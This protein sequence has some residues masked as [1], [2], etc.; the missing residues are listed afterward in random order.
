MKNSVMKKMLA[1]LLALLMMIPMTVFSIAAEQTVAQNTPQIIPVSDGTD[2]SDVGDRW[3]G[4]TAQY[5]ADGTVATIVEGVPALQRPGTVLEMV[6]TTKTARDISN[7]NTLVFDL[8]LENAVG[9]ANATFYFELRSL[10]YTGDDHELQFV[11]ELNSLVDYILK[12]GWHHIEIPLS[13]FGESADFDPT[14]WSFFRIYNSAADVALRENGEIVKDEDGNTVYTRQNVQNTIGTAGK[15]TVFKI[16]NMY[17]TDAS[18]AMPTE[19]DEV[20]LKMGIDPAKHVIN[21]TATADIPAAAPPL[22]FV[23][24]PTTALNI[25]QYSTVNFDVYL[26]HEDAQQREYFLELTSSGEPDKEEDLIKSKANNWASLAEFADMAGIELSAGWNRI[27]IPVSARTK[28]T[29]MDATQFDFFRIYNKSWVKGTYADGETRSVVFARA[30]LG[31]YKMGGAEVDFWSGSSTHGVSIVSTTHKSSVADVIKADGTKGADG[32]NEWVWFNTASSVTLK[33]TEAWGGLKMTSATPN[34]AN[35]Y[36]IQ[37]DIWMSDAA[38]GDNL[39]FLEFSSSGAAD[40]QEIQARK[41]SLNQLNGQTLEAGKWQTVTILTSA[42]TDKTSPAFVPQN[43]NYIRFWKSGETTFANGLVVATRN[44]RALNNVDEASTDENGNP[45]ARMN[46][47]KDISSGNVLTVAGVDGRVN[48]TA[49]NMLNVAVGGNL[50]DTANYNINEVRLKSALD[51]S[52]ADHIGFDLY[53]ENLSYWGNTVKFRIDMTSSGQSD[54]QQILTSG[55]SIPQM[56]GDYVVNADG[57]RG[58]L[59]DGWNHIEMPIYTLFYGKVNNASDAR[60]AFNPKTFNYIRTFA[61]GGTKKTAEQKA[62]AAIDNVTFFDGGVIGTRD[63]VITYGVGD[64]IK[65]AFNGATA[66]DTR[67]DMSEHHP[68]DISDKT[69]L[70]FDVFATGMSLSDNAFTVAISSGTSGDLQQTTL[71]IDLDDYGVTEGAWSTVEIPLSHFDFTVKDSAGETVDMTDIVRVSL[72]TT[73]DL[74]AGYKLDT[75][76]I[77]FEKSGGFGPA[78]TSAQPTLRESID[79]TIKATTPTSLAQTAAIEFVLGGEAGMTRSYA[80]ATLFSTSANGMS[81]VWVTDFTDIPAHRMTDTLSMTVWYVDANGSLAKGAT[82]DYSV[83]E[84]ITNILA[85]TTDR[86]LITLLSDLLAY[87]AAAQTYVDYNMDALVSDIDESL[88]TKLTPST[89]TDPAV[90]DTLLSGAPVDDDFDATFK[91]ATLVLDGTVHIR[92]TFAAGKVDGLTLNVGG[93]AYTTFEMD[94]EGRYYL[95]VPVYAYDFATVFNAYFGTNADYSLNYSVNHYIAKMRPAA[96]AK[97]G[98]LLESLYNYGVSAA[99]Y[100]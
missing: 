47:G 93:K 39:L 35:L 14:R 95:D 6:Y 31:G 94:E 78:V 27:E 28:S 60:V 9:I 72:L 66:K 8:Y 26:S 71:T 34:C 96:G 67:F 83:Q 57:S 21:Y 30:S 69:T 90:L 12:D 80:P 5:T 24:K 76:N 88:A 49:L 81:R 77:R 33:S 68:H 91:S 85:K 41:L 23:G 1:M 63:D 73:A 40:V 50:V 86:K 53:L 89:Y 18:V 37:F 48:N 44:F 13:T 36:G 100:Q 64:K 2:R 55:L 43:F 29:G 70:K 52:K 65:T 61:M 22:Q 11:A 92:Y 4:N 19:S 51:I 32:V 56:F 99:A 16:D 45:V 59:K 54:H 62:V 20:I 97:L 74:P 98:T 75:D 25:D 7:M 17:F 79:F 15:N 42:F 38:F 46:V 87:G 10:G 58:E 82:K 3:F 84:Y